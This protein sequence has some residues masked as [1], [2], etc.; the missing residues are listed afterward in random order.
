M[1]DILTSVEQELRKRAMDQF[2]RKL[3]D[4]LHALRSVVADNA[5]GMFNRS[6][7]DIDADIDALRE[8]IL[9]KLKDRVQDD[10]VRKG[11]A[12]LLRALSGE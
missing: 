3:D 5:G 8:S 2:E 10:A 4:A 1:V 9:S 6:P 12:L 11:A 7:S